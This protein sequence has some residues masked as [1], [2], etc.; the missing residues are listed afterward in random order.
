MRG[1]RRHLTFLEISLFFL[2][3]LG[4]GS[5]TAPDSGFSQEGFGNVRKFWASCTKR[6]QARMIRAARACHCV[7]WFMI[8]ALS[9]SYVISYVIS[10]ASS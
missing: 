1:A 4:H 6:R 2:L 9:I 3:I 8:V 5:Y 10:Y 7:G